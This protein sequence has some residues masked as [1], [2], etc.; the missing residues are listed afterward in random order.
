MKQRLK[1]L[2]GSVLHHLA[3]PL[4]RGVA[5]GDLDGKNARLKRIVSDY[6]THRD[7]QKGDVESLRGRLADY[8]QSGRGDDFYDAYPERFENWFLGEHYPVVEALGRELEKRPEIQRL[9]EVGCGDGKVLQHLSEKFPQFTSATGI[10]LN[11][12]IIEQNRAIYR[13]T[14]LQ[15]E[16][17]DLHSWLQSYRGSGILLT[18]YGGVL[19]YLTQAELEEIFTVFRN[20]AAPVM[21]VLVEPI[22]KDFDLE[23]ETVSRPYGA[24][25]SFSHPH[26]YLLEKAG[27][28]IDFEEVKMMQ[29]RWMLM[30][31]SAQQ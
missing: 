12:S 3:P 31:A 27:W 29:H 26:R 1:L 8:W 21:L 23:E 16:A 30:I 28:T 18:S 19:E 25:N 5:S 24:E 6:Q 13:E 17:A 14:K 9:I 11:Q 2:A 22:A 20:M 15:F 4:S 10:D 7:A